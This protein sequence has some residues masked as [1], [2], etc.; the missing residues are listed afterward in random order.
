VPLTL[1]IIFGLLVAAFRSVS[2]A[3]LVAMSVPF[4][5]AGGVF[6]QWALGYAMTTA[7][8]IGYISVFAVAAQTG[9]IMVIFIREALAA[10]NPE[11]S[12][13]EAVITGSTARLR[14][15]TGAGT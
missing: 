4:A 8:I 11:D 1:V 9:I 7:V 5:L 6:L 12:F 15:M 3:F 10:R 13:V 14:P 2:E